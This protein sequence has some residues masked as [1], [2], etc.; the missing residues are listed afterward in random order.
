MGMVIS[1]RIGVYG[2]ERTERLSLGRRHCE[3]IQTA[4]SSEATLSSVKAGQRG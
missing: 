4:N 2:C 3:L 1:C